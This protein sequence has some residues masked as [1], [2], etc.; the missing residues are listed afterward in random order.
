MIF[1]QDPNNMVLFQNFLAYGFPLKTGIY[2]GGSVSISRSSQQF[3][4]V[5][6]KMSLIQGYQWT[7]LDPQDENDKFFDAMEGRIGENTLK[8]LLVGSWR[9]FPRRNLFGRG[10]AA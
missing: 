9:N 8:I 10:A 6:A 3:S 7:T 5:S 2:L 4:V 1:T